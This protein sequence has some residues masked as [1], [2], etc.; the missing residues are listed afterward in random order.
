MSEQKDKLRLELARI[1]L[2]F[3]KID[4]AFAG[5]IAIDKMVALI[6]PLIEEAKKEIADK[7]TVKHTDDC[8]W[9]GYVTG[10][11]CGDKEYHYPCTCGAV[12]QLQH[13]IK[14]IKG[15]K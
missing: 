9:Y 5:T 4:D 7:L 14:E 2:D 11:S 8:R 13:T 12:R 1:L 3:E 6:E 10:G 15:E